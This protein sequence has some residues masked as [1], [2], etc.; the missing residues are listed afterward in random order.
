MTATKTNERPGTKAVLRHFHMSSSKARQ[1]LNLIRG[2][3]VNQAADILKGVEREAARVISKVLE[4]A[5]ANAVHNDGQIAEDLYIASAYADEGTTMKRWRPR[6]RGR[7]TRIRKRTTHITI[8]V[9]RMDDDRLEQRLAARQAAGV[10]RSRRVAGSQRRAD[11]QQRGRRRDAAREADLEAVE[12]E[13]GTDEE[14]VETEVVEVET[15]ET[16]D[17]ETSAVTDSKET[18]EEEAKPKKAAAKKTTA[19]KAPAKKAAATTTK[20]AA[21]SNDDDAESEEEG[22]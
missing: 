7:A 15:V 10:E 11:Q 22:K 1:V 8:I 5:I 4:S 9:A 16:V 6:A 20:K 14:E 2:K 12:A 21:A 18:D 19:K 17:A 3:D 13:A